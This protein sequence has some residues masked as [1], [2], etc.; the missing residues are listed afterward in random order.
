MHCFDRILRASPGTVT[1][2]FRLQICLEDWLD[3]HHCRR[4]YHSIPDRRHSQRA[5]PS[6]GFLDPHP[7][8]CRRSVAFTFQLRR[9]FAQPPLPAVLLDVFEALSVHPRRS[10]I[11]FAFPVGE[12]QNVF[13][14]HLVVQLMKAALGLLL[15][16]RVQRPL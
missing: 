3:H 14:P 5:L 7:A 16:L 13:S 8:Y 11:G 1:V 2:L 10:A 9:H 15:R 4:L 12:L 6:I